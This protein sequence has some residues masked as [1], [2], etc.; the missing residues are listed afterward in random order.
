[1]THV[2]TQVILFAASFAVACCMQN[3]LARSPPMGWSRFVEKQRQQ[4]VLNAFASSSKYPQTKHSWNG[5]N[6]PTSPQVI[7]ATA[8]AL[9]RLGLKE[10]G[11]VHVD[12]DGA[13]F[14]FARADG[15]PQGPG[16]VHG[17]DMKVNLGQGLFFL[18]RGMF[19]HHCC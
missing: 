14:P 15:P 19:P 17:W 10:L 18:H 7:K 1:M 9:E 5:Y 3:G 2:L 8:A 11:Y 12:V 13:W 4:I 16:A 6:N